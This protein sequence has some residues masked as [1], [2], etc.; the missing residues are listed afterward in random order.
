MRRHQTSRGGFVMIGSAA[1]RTGTRSQ[2]VRCA[3]NYGDA[4]QTPTI[5]PNQG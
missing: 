5:V 2:V 1:W 3:S 4:G